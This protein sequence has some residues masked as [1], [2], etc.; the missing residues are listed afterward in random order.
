MTTRFQS[1]PDVQREAPEQLAEHVATS[2]RLHR[3]G[4]LLMAGAFLDRPGEPVRTMGRAR[5]PWGGATLRGERPF[6]PRRAR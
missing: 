3:E 4:L 6:R 2:K 1:F 5:L